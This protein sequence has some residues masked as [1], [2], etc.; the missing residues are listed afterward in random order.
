[1]FIARNSPLIVGKL[2]AEQTGHD[3]VQ[4]TLEITEY[5]SARLIRLDL[6]G[7]SYLA[8]ASDWSYKEARSRVYTQIVQAVSFQFFAWSFV[9]GVSRLVSI[10]LVSYVAS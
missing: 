5:T 7:R 8:K 6:A 2:S 10:A 4:I 1:M 9:T 3:R